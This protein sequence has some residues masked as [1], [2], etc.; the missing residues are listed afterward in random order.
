MK[1]D[2]YKRFEI[3]ENHLPV[4]RSELYKVLE[5]NEKRA[6]TKIKE[7]RDAVE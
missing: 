4:Y 5:G 1:R 2:I 6:L 7:V 3:I